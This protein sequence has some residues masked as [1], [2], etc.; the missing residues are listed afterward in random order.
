M[1]GNESRAVTRR[2]AAAY[3]RVLSE[4][5]TSLGSECLRTRRIYPLASI[6]VFSLLLIAG[7]RHTPRI[8]GSSD[9]SREWHEFQGTWIAAGSR[10]T[11]ELGDSRRASIA[12]FTGSLL[13]AGVSRPAVGFRAEAI[14]LSDTATG[15]MG[16]AVWTDERGDKVFSELHGQWIATSNK[17]TGTFVGGTGRY[18]GAEGTYEFSWRFVIEANDATV[19]GQSMGLKGRIRGGPSQV[20]PN[21]NGPTP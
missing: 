13:L 21:A 20:T 6:A 3:C 9:S 7:C 15:M 12:D 16:R 14:V 17:V 18:S 8:S 10:Q 11:L 4:V 1:R 19:H 2:A 5:N